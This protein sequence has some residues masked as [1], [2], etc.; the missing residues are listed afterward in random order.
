MYNKIFVFVQSSMKQ[1]FVRHALLIFDFIKIILI[2]IFVVLGLLKLI[3]KF[4]NKFYQLFMYIY[5]GQFNL[6]M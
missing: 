2:V 3:F 4:Q 5:A 6:V 1:L